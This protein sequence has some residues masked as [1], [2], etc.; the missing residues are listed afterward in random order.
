MALKRITYPDRE[1]WLAGRGNGI[2]ASEAAAIVGLSPWMT[3]MELWH[4]KTGQAQH[5]DLSTNAAIEL[6][7]R[8]EPALRGLY[9][10]MHPE[11]RIEY[12]AYDILFQEERPWL[13][14]TLDGETI[15]A[16]ESRGV[17]EIKSSTPG[18][19][20]EWEKWKGRVPD[21]YFVQVLHQLLATGYD[22]AVLFAGLL[23][24]EGDLSTREYEFSR[25]DY[26][27]DLAWLLDKEERFWHNVKTRTMPPMV[28]RL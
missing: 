20:V 6:G 27:S 28:I 21:H 18:K 7:V 25:E 8:L 12:H 15:S 4:Q 13:F 1:S 17:L 26:E 5:K 3:S 19:A 9:G 11:Q 14:A 16:D 22:K 10:A 2:G 23:T 24:L